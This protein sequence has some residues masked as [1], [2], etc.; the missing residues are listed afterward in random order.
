[1][2]KTLKDNAIVVDGGAG[3]I[4]TKILIETLILVQVHPAGGESV[5]ITKRESWLV[6]QFHYRRLSVIVCLWS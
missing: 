6:D 1:M 5:K 2:D 4:C 3:G